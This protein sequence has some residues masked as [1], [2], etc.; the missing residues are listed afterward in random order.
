MAETHLI[1]PSQHSSAQ[2]LDPPPPTP[3]N[4]EEHGGAEVVIKASSTILNLFLSEGPS[5][6]CL[7]KEGGQNVKEGPCCSELFKSG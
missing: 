2:H 5:L 3:R 7:Q 1:A 6:S 4:S